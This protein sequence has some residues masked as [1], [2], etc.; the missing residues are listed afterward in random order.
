MWRTGAG[1][2]LQL[3]ALA[4]EAR[5][6]KRRCAG[7]PPSLL[8][9]LRA[10][11]AR[12]CTGASPPQ[13]SAATADVVCPSCSRRRFRG[14]AGAGRVW[15]RPSMGPRLRRPHHHR[16]PAPTGSSRRPA[17]RRAPSERQVGCHSVS[18]DSCPGSESTAAGGSAQ[19]VGSSI[20]SHAPGRPRARPIPRREFF[21]RCDPRGCRACRVRQGRR[22]RGRAATTFRRL[23][24]ATG[25]VA[26]SRSVLSHGVARRLTS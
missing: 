10:S 19:P 1:T 4:S 18:A 8:I 2:V 15:D 24:A 23:V 11:E 20:S 26:V 21:L 22:R 3:A 13:P 7:A 17:H 9:N 14:G 12:L 5:F 16:R 6:S 25:S